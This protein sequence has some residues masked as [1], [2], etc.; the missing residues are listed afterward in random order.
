MAKGAKIRTETA[1]LTALL[2]AASVVAGTPVIKDFSSKGGRTT[3]KTGPKDRMYLVQAGDKITFTIKTDGAQEYRW[4]VN[5]KLQEA[6]TPFFTWTVPAEKGIWEIHVTVGS[7]DGQSH[8]EWV[9]S[10]LPKAEAPN[11]FEYFSDGK[12]SARRE[13]DP[14]ARPMKEWTVEEKEYNPPSAER[15]WMEPGKGGQQA[16]A[17]RVPSKT[18]YGT[19][20]FRF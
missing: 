9:V 12:Y 16:H 3:N 8:R 14:W 20:R 13:T 7:K 5:K 2:A 10:T 6:N 19:W 15:C 17:F 18:A 11:L 4:L 1:F